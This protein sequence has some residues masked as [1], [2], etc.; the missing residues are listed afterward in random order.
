[1][2]RR[3]PIWN[4]V[5]AISRITAAILWDLKVWQTEYVP[6]DGPAILVCNHQSFLDPVMVALRLYR[7]V[8]YFARSDLF[9]NP[10][11]GWFIR[12]LNAFPVRRGEADIGALRQALRCLADGNLLCFFAE[13]HRTPDGEIGPI[14]K[15]IT[16]LIRKSRV[17][18]IPVVI[19]GSFDALPRHRWV[20]DK[21]VRVLFGPPLDVQDRSADEII[22]N[23]DVTF[24]SMQARLRAWQAL[25]RKGYRP[26]PP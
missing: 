5:H 25:A 1:M 10:A 14:Q 3:T 20:Q 13:G 6:T 17:P 11:F 19:D 15:G 2:M 21:P 8:S 16:L 26:P 23:I 22:R 4:T 24:R 18:V 12:S 7:P 9:N